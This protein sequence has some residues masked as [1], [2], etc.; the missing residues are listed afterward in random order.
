MYNFWVLQEV[1]DIYLV[2][3]CNKRLIE[4]MGEFT[5]FIALNYVCNA[6]LH[7]FTHKLFSSEQMR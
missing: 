3:L 4:Y 2:T 5:F 1:E 7:F 6:I